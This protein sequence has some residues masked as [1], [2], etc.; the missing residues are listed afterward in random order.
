ME[1]LK[2]CK[3]YIPATLYIKDSYQNN[4]KHKPPSPKSFFHRRRTKPVEN[5]PAITDIF[6]SISTRGIVHGHTS[7][8]L[9]IKIKGGTLNHVRAEPE[10][11]ARAAAR[12]KPPK[13][14]RSAAA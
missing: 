1:I 12:A 7:S 5:A 3:V 6:F 9:Y 4:K 13:E 8:L 2:A 10:L 11:S 14:G